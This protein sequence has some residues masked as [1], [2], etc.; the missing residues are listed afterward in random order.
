MKFYYIWA[1]LFN[2]EF[3]NTNKIEIKIWNMSPKNTIK[4]IN[5][6]KFYSVHFGLIRS[7]LFSSV[8]FGFIW[9]TLVLFSPFSPHWF[10]SIHFKSVRSTLVPFGPFCPLWSTLVLLEPF[11]PHR[12]SSVHSIHF[13]SIWSILILVLFSWRWSYSI[14]FG[15]TRS[16]LVLFS[17]ICS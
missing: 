4:M 16:D 9:S 13:D 17:P 14:H 15:P 6:Q 3:K 8:H 1:K 5:I 10:Y 2:F 12:S 11:S 7:I